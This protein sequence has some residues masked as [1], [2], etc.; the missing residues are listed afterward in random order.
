MLEKDLNRR[1][2]AVLIKKQVKKSVIILFIISFCAFAFQPVYAQLEGSQ[3]SVNAVAA[4]A[5]VQ[6]GQNIFEIIGNIINIAL[7]MVGVILLVMILY[8]GYQYMT[9]GGNTEQV[10][11]ATA[12]IRNAIIGLLIILASFAIVNFI[13]NWLTGAGPGFA[14][15]GYQWQAPQTFQQ[16]SNSGSLGA[17]VI[18][19]HYPER[20]QQNIPRNTSIAISFKEAID[21]ASFIQDW[22]VATPDLYELNSSLIKIHPQDNANQDLQPDQARVTVSAD[23]KTVVIKPNNPLGNSQSPVWYEVE[24]TGGS[25]GIKNASGTAVFTGSFS[26]GYNW[27]FEVSTEIDTTPPQIVSHI[28]YNN[29]VYDRNI[30]VQINFDEPMLPMSVAGIFQKQNPNINFQNIVTSENQGGSSEVI[31]GEYRISNGYRTVEFITTDACGTNSCL[32]TMYCLPPDAGIDVLVKAATLSANPPQAAEIGPFGFDGAV[33]MAGNSLDGDG[34]G[35]AQGPQPGGND[36]YRFNFATNNEINL[37]APVIT[38]LNPEVLQGQ[39]AVDQNVEITWDS[40]LMSY[41]INTGSVFMTRAG[42]AEDALGPKGGDTW[43]FFPTSQKLNAAG[44]PV[45]PSEEPVATKIE[46]HHRPF[47]PSEIPPANSNPWDYLSLYAPQ[48]NQNLMNIYQNCFNPAT[49][50]LDG[51]GT[52]NSGGPNNPNLCNEAPFNDICENSPNWRP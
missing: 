7:G 21:P 42:P 48:V 50:D 47:L 29:G 12:R 52:V 43:W 19:Y 27:D 35:A 1:T 16:Y 37:S 10:Q 5:G 13:I 38:A 23:K 44:N 20:N 33:D 14:P 6:P 51:D 18:E 28:P 22:T 36:D 34:D 24:L 45:A 49:S 25:D 8:S 26:D 3:E 15:S 46:L 40:I 39:I 4:A 32:V 30:V 17:G 9:A 11:K 41:S 31:E 2:A